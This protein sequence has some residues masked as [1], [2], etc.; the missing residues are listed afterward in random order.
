MDTVDDPLQGWIMDRTK[1]GKWGKYKP[2]IIL[3]TVITAI[4]L[5]ALY[6]LP[7][8]VTSSPVFTTVYVLF[9][10][11]LYDIGTS[12]YAANPLMQTMSPDT[13]IRAKLTVYPRVFGMLVSIPFAFILQIVAVSTTAWEICMTPLLS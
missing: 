13:G 4:S 6:C 11:L 8:A 10:Y 2:Y 9:F 1:P 12:F 5:L 3:S 7:S